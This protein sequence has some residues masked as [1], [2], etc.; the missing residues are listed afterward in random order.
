MFSDDNAVS[1][2]SAINSMSNTQ[3]YTMSSV[4]NAIE[5]LV[6]CGLHS[7][8]LNFGYCDFLLMRHFQK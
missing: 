2:L 3:I 6:R 4:S 8:F 5:N 1:W 7:C